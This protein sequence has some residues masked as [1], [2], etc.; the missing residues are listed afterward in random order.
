MFQYFFDNI[1]IFYTGNNV[2]FAAT[3]LTLRYPEAAPS[4]ENTRFSRCAQF[5]E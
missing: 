5:I 4:M 3:L 2:H 1:R